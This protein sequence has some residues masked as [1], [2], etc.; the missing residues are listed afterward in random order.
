M[1]K[2][3]LTFCILLTTTAA[4]ADLRTRDDVTPSPFNQ[5]LDRDSTKTKWVY[6]SL[7]AICEI[8][9]LA[10]YHPLDSRL[11]DNGLIRVFDMSRYEVAVA[12]ARITD[13]EDNHVSLWDATEKSLELVDAMAA[14]Q[15]E[16]AY[17]IKRLG[18][19]PGAIEYSK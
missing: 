19:R 15:I 12:V 6:E 3:L 13:S 10:K 11:E 7:A 14:M 9:T 5:L 16:F 1:N 4:R 2:F 8:E 18:V 17:E